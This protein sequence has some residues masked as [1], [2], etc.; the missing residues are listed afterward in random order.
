MGK[1][2]RDEHA[3]KKK[4]GG[5]R[6]LGKKST[7][8]HHQTNLYTNL[9]SFFPLPLCRLSA[10]LHESN[11]PPAQAF[12]G[13]ILWCDE[14][15]GVWL[16][17]FSTHRA[18]VLAPD[19]GSTAVAPLPRACHPCSLRGRKH[20]R[21]HT[22]EET[23]LEHCSSSTDTRTGIRTQDKGG[24]KGAAAF[25]TSSEQASERNDARGH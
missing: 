20:R 21:K 10:T 15:W 22:R 24:K 4:K 16:P 17:G 7:T 19:L 5:G 11:F 3:D 2:H 13:S 18:S 6:R 9:V 12:Q 25:S 23:Q 1:R 8:D 14:G